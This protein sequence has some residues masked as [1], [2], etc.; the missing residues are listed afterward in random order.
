MYR[1][2]K[3]ILLTIAFVV[4]TPLVVTTMRL[5]LEVGSP[6]DYLVGFGVTIVSFVI[7]A[8]SLPP[9]TGFSWERSI[10][11][12]VVSGLFVLSFY[13]GMDPQMTEEYG[14]QIWLA[15]VVIWLATSIWIALGALLGKEDSWPVAS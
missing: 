9:I 3:R 8:R 1:D 5:L 13:Y 10:E 14:G 2:I 4:L 12:V 7:V 6:Y 11:V 15:S